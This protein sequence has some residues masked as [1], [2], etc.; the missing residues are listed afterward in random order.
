MSEAGCEVLSESRGG[1]L[2]ALREKLAGDPFRELAAL[3][4]V[5]AAAVATPLA[6]VPYA[7]RVLGPQAW[8]TY[9][10]FH[11]L[12]LYASFV[13]EY[14][15]NLSATREVARLRESAGGR[16]R[17]L[18]E[19]FAAKLALVALLLAGAAAASYFVPLVAAHRWLMAGAMLF[20][21]SHGM[22]LVWYFQGTAQVRRIAWAEI[23]CRALA[24]ILTFALVRGPQ[25]DWLL[26]GIHGAS[27]LLAA[28]AGTAIAAADCGIGRLCPRGAW[29][30]LRQGFPLFFF[31]GA[32]SLYTVANGLILSMFAP[33]LAVG[34]FAGGERIGKGFAGLLNPLVQAWY[35]RVN[36]AAGD[37]REFER[38]RRRGLILMTGAGLAI[39]LI[40]LTGAPLLV[41]LLLGPG[42]EPA[43][44]VLRIFALLPPVTALGATLGLHGML[45]LGRDR[46]FNTVVTL[47]GAVN[48]ALAALLAGRWRAEGMAAAVVSA[49]SF[50]AVSF[51]I[52]LWRAGF[53]PV[54]R[55]SV[56]KEASE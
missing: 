34:F 49:E 17:L 33:P 36:H 31:R 27:L 19:V 48:L 2:D 29:K 12:A 10:I 13:V 6:I 38:L 5:H 52:Y 26:L 56:R 41:R 51:F 20:A 43:V 18:G 46:A 45:P 21:V 39:G 44:N 8:G 4:A 15:F 47:A 37:A 53:N 28:I 25:D 16:A 30:A 55:T 1:L 11:S 14:G 3:Y 7:A 50:V 23:G 42:F 40:V 22:G 24:V 9:S 54:V 35:A 32:A